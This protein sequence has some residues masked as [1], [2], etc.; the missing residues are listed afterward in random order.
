[1]QKGKTASEEKD[2]RAEKDSAD[3]VGVRGTGAS[4]QANFGMALN[5]AD[6]LFSVRREPVANRIVFQIAHDVFDNWFRVEEISEKPDPN[7]D[8]EV[9]KILSELNAKAV[10][11]QMAVFERLFGW[12]GK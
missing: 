4:W 10:F 5:E 7:F 12:V 11:T 6:L 2:R 3:T 8:R 1:M 9:Q